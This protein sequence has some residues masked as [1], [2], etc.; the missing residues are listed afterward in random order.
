M[1]KGMKFGEINSDFLCRVCNSLPNP[2]VKGVG[3]FSPAEKE[4][5]PETMKKETEHLVCLP[6]KSF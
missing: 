3:T 4:E 1:I 2:K 5:S 6:Q